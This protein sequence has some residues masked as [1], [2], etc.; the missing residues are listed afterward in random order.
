MRPVEG[1]H[2]E[3]PKLA[4]IFNKNKQTAKVKTV[5]LEVFKR[6]NSLH[7]AQNALRLN[8]GSNLKTSRNR[9]PNQSKKSLLQHN[10]SF[11]WEQ[12]FPWDLIGKCLGWS[13]WDMQDEGGKPHV[14]R[15]AQA[16]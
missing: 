15:C 8:L 9:Y 6:K 13:G 11:T 3:T 5:S 14:Q 12:T 2:K 10:N 16:A 1:L 4:T 7:L